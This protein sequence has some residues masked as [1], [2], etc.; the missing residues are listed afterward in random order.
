MLEETK[1]FERMKVYYYCA[2]QLDLP[3]YSPT[4]TLRQ[5][6]PCF[7]SRVFSS[8]HGP[9]SLHVLYPHRTIT[10]CASTT[11]T[12]VLYIASALYGKLLDTFQP[13]GFVISQ[14]VVPFALCSEISQFVVPFARR[15]AHNGR[16]VCQ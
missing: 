7:C 16:A 10:M 13:V 2:S 9:Q 15:R 5:Y 3:P 11:P 6:E 8:P 4:V 1:A 12:Y 14:L